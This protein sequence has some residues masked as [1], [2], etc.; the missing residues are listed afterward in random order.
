MQYFWT[1][2][3]S[4]S[5]RTLAAWG[6]RVVDGGQRTLCRLL[7]LHIVHL[8]V[9]ESLVCVFSV[10]VLS[11]CVGGVVFLSSCKPATSSSALTRVRITIGGGVLF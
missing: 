3:S 10:L 4:V 2:F 9:M 7:C 6:N 8:I 1:L 11:I 5:D